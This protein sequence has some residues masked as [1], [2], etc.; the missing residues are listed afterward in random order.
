M[1][2]ATPID[3]AHAAWV[4]PHPNDDK[5]T[6]YLLQKVKTP[7]HDNPTPDPV[8][9]TNALNAIVS[10]DSIQIDETWRAE[11]GI[12]RLVGSTDPLVARRIAELFERHNRHIAA[13]PYKPTFP[14]LRAGDKVRVA[15]VN[16]VRNAHHMIRTDHHKTGHNPRDD[17]EAA[18]PPPPPGST[19]CIQII[20]KRVA[21]VLWKFNL[22]HRAEAVPGRQ[23]DALAVAAKKESRDT[24]KLETRLLQISSG[25]D[26]P[27]ELEA[28]GKAFRTWTKRD[29]NR[30]KLQKLKHW[31]RSSR[32]LLAQRI[33]NRK[34]T[35]V[36][37]RVYRAP[38]LS[39]PEMATLVQPSSFNQ[40]SFGMPPAPSNGFPA[41]PTSA[42]R[43]PWGATSN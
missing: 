39:A 28:L 4:G 3:Q 10:D 38:R 16:L 27:A 13:I 32:L 35:F 30:F 33:L 12:F 7:R 2:K 17:L 23:T 20:W 31:S 29:G 9:F 1:T 14:I 15:R 41:P 25:P 37:H 36:L 8:A 26:S 24:F 42:A 5:V 21:G 18:M 34:W 22:K 6:L 43:R 11:H 19:Y 40:T